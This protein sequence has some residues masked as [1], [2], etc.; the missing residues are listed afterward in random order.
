MPALFTMMSSRPN[1][2]TVASIE[3]LQVGDLAD[4]GV[5]TDGSIAQR[6]DMLFEFL[7]RIRVGDIVDRDVRALLGQLEH[8]SLADAAVAAGDDGD[9]PFKSMMKLHYFAVFTEAGRRNFRRRR[10]PASR[11]AFRHFDPAPESALFLLK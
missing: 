2:F 5:H 6:G 3:P 1:A 8:D 11:F 4:V 7:G 9:L 10:H